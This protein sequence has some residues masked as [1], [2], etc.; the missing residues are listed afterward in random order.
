MDLFNYIDLQSGNIP[1]I[2]WWTAKSDT[3]SAEEFLSAKK[4][5]LMTKFDESHNVLAF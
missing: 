4:H 3:W 1:Y 5:V 2:Y